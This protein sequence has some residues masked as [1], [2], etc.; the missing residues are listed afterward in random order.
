MYTAVAEVLRQFLG[1]EFPVV[2][3][4]NPFYPTSLGCCFQL[5]NLSFNFSME[6]DLAFKK[7]TDDT[8]V[9]SWYRVTKN[10]V[11]PLVGFLLDRIHHYGPIEVALVIGDPIL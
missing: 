7:R 10:C 1:Y 3:H 6:S 2:V 8:A 9:T 5:R 11:P 4:S